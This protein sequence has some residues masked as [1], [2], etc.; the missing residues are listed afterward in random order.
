MF[1]GSSEAWNVLWN[2]PCLSV[3]LSV[4]ANKFLKRPSKDNKN[5][6]SWGG[7]QL[8]IRNYSKNLNV[9]AQN[10]VQICAE[11]V[12][13]PQLQIFSC[14]WDFAVKIAKLPL[15]VYGCSKFFPNIF[16]QFL[17]LHASDSVRMQWKNQFS[18]PEVV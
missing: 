3:Y 16:L 17:I 2:Q 14:S 18:L 11:L 15:K 1:F 10:M 5:M 8:F 13:R 7:F 4:S 12:Q 6:H 9:F